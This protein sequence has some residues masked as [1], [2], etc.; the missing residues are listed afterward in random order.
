ML[1][2]P[3]LIRARGQAL[4][5]FTS[6]WF[7]H[8]AET[9]CVRVSSA[10]VVTKYDISSSPR[11]NAKSLANF[12]SCFNDCVSGDTMYI[13]PYTIQLDAAV[14]YQCANGVTY[15]GC[16]YNETI[17]NSNQLV[18]VFECIIN[19]NGTCHLWDFAVNGTLTDGTFQ[20]P[21]GA[22]HGQQFTGCTL[23]RLKVG[24]QSDCFFFSSL[25]SNAV[26][27]DCIFQSTYDCVAVLNTAT[28]TFN[29]CRFTSSGKFPGTP[30]EG[31]GL[32]NNNCANLDRG[33]TNFNNCTFTSTG[34]AESIYTRG[35]W[36]R[37]IAVSTS[38]DCT[39][40][41]AAPA[42]DIYDV[43]N[44]TGTATLVRGTGSGVAGAYLTS[45]TVV[46]P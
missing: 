30:A 32:Y 29:R 18:A 26:I 38:T 6:A 34:H 41:T 5:D 3:I 10:G 46:G 33:T 44:V 13:G 28:F 43:M 37:S 21:I 17:L 42:G 20:F 8:F 24:G 14:G 27:N 12:T 36:V 31:A 11:T 25:N 2:V 9:T 1:S 15:R 7:Y 45:G 23:N 22:R 40:T 16:G 4:G 39:F 35:I 19:L